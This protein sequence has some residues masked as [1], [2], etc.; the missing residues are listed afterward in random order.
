MRKVM[1]RQQAQTSKDR[2]ERFVRTVLDDDERADDL[3]DESL[4]D[5]ADRK[6]VRIANPRRVSPHILE[7]SVTVAKGQSKA[8]LQDRIKELEDENAD[9]NQQL[10]DV[11][12]KVEDLLDLVAP[13]EGDDGDVDGD[14]D[15][16]QGDD[17]DD[18][19]D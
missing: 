15:D 4:E 6:G 7:R 18:D 17:Q 14:Q 1:T 3:A 19:Q 9:L 8:D 10:D 12:D 16:D 2:G 11:T 13:D 5:W